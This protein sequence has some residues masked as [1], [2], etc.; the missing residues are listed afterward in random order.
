MARTHE[1]GARELISPSSIEMLAGT[2]EMLYS[3][4]PLGSVILF[5]HSECNIAELFG[6]FSCKWVLAT[7]SFGV[8]FHTEESASDATHAACKSILR[9]RT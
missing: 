9:I 3:C 1:T 8:T 2:M 7:T 5:G 4:D 6:L